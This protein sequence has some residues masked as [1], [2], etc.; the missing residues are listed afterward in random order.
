VQVSGYWANRPQVPAEMGENHPRIEDPHRRE[1]EA[2]L[3]EAGAAILHLP[4]S[5]DFTCTQ[6]R[7]RMRSMRRLASKLSTRSPSRDRWASRQG[8]T[9][10]SLNEVSADTGIPNQ[11]ALS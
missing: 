1:A 6:A 2:A 9:E 11:T 5:T 8:L 10:P 7:R 4:N 3:W